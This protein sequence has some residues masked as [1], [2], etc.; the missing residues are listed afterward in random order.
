MLEK[1]A[2]DSFHDVLFSQTLFWQRYA[3]LQE[4]FTVFCLAFKRA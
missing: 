1:R 2:L 4:G 3:A